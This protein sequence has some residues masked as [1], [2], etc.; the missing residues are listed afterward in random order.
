[1]PSYK[2]HLVGGAATYLLTT[3]LLTRFAPWFSHDP[4]LHA[5]FISFSLLGSIFPDIDIPSRMQTLFF[6]C[7]PFVLPCALFFNTHLFLILSIVCIFVILVRHR[8]TTHQIW[9]LIALPLFAGLYVVQ[10]YPQSK[11][12]IFPICT[13]FSAAALSHR[14]LDFGP[15]RFFTQK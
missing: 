10:L 1:M 14:L 4:A 11:S 15:R 13:Y 6:R 12:V 2:V 8:T 3:H 9:F 5:L 7:M